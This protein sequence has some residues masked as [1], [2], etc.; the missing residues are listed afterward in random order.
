MDIGLVLKSNGG[1]LWDWD[2]R[3]GVTIGC[4]NRL[5]FSMGWQ[6]LIWFLQG[7]GGYLLLVMNLVLV[8]GLL[9][10]WWYMGCPILEIKRHQ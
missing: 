8:A 2:W 6:E 5:V 4:H 1:G 3:G 10:R 7:S 9:Y